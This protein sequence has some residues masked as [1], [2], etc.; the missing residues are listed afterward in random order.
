MKFQIKHECRG[1]IR[2][3]MAQ[4]R[5]TMEQADLLEAWLQTLPAVERAAVHERTRCAVIEYRGS[6]RALL[7]ALKGF[8]YQDKGLSELGQVHSSRALNRAYEEKLVGMVI[9]KAVRSLVF[10][11]ASAGSLRHCQGGALSASGA[12][13]LAEG[14]A[15]CGGA[16]PRNMPIPSRETRL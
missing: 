7:E 9:C 10:S 11:G 3:Q 8:S 13:L 1:R 6:R 5:M 16:G 15:S 12:G 14:A 2:V 4:A